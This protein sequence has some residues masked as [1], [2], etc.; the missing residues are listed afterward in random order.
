MRIFITFIL[1]LI[2]IGADQYS[3]YWF[4]QHFTLHESKILFPGFAWTLV[5]N[6]GA[7][8]GLLGNGFIWQKVL[9]S[10]IA[11]IVSAVLFCLIV[12]QKISKLER[13]AYFCVCAG[14]LGNLIDRIRQGYVVDFIDWYYQTWHWPA[15]NVADILICFGA[16]LLA[17]SWLPFCKKSAHT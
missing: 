14:A 17:V 2:T 12:N 6:H 8:F 15:F 1:L 3:K 11:I 4:V 16:F 10:T 9:L 13:V 5:Y 7:A